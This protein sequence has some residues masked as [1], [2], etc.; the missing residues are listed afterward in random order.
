MPFFH[1]NQIEGEQ[2]VKQFLGIGE[3]GLQDM[4]DLVQAV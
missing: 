3:I 1:I 4:P 2:Q